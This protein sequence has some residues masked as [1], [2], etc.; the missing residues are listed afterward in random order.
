MSI[1]YIEITFSNIFSLHP[2]SLKTRSEQYRFTD[3]IK[4]N[5]RNFPQKSRKLEIG[6]FK[7]RQPSSYAG[8]M[9]ILA[10][11]GVNKIL[12]LRGDHTPPLFL[13]DEII[14]PKYEEKNCN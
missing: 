8:N 11:E 3:E 4:E 2:S 13:K 14:K 5:P 7:F 6:S 1:G 12:N 9:V 10:R